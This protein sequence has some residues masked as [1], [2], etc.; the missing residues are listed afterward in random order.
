M[1]DELLL[2]TAIGGHRAALPAAAISSVI[3]IEGIEAIPLARA[4]V[5]GL[6]TLR[7]RVLT[8]IDCR[9]ALGLTE[10]AGTAR[11][12]VVIE[13]GGHGYALLV[14]EVRDVTPA[15]SEPAAPRA[16]PGPGWAAALVGM[17]ETASG[18][19]L[20]LDPARL[21]VGPGPSAASGLMAA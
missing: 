8:V 12:A 15:L 13:V 5:A 19:V 2:V 3:E 7:S 14:D 17:V 10:T 6:T 11:E 20:V 21:A 4:P 9:A 16:D 1:I 18:P